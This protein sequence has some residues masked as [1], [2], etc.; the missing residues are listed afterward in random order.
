LTKT[1]EAILVLVLKHLDE[2]VFIA[3]QTLYIY[4]YTTFCTYIHTDTYM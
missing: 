3:F 2:N 1:P 4:I